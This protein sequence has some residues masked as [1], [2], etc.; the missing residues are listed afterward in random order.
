MQAAERRGSLAQPHLLEQLIQ[1]EGITRL[2]RPHEA[3]RPP[4]S[5]E[6]LRQLLYWS[7]SS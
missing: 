5:G 4:I 7:Q 1:P 6:H 3:M 2:A